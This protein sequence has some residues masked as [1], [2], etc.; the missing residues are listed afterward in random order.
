M[1]GRKTRHWSSG[2]AI[3][4][5]MKREE[6]A[7]NEEFERFM[8]RAFLRDGDNIHTGEA[9]LLAC[10]LHTKG[11]SREGKDMSVLRTIMHDKNM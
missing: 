10:L 4:F 3:I 7:F 2:H 8:Y 9:L 11:G 1:C 5:P 6:S